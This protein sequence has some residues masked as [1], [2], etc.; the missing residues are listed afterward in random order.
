MRLLDFVFNGS[1]ALVITQSVPIAGVL[2]VFSF[3][4]VP[5][6]IGALLAQRLPTRLVIGVAGRHRPEP[7]RSRHR[8]ARFRCRQRDSARRTSRRS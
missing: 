4:L 7:M 1:F 8:A 5:A 6:T 3:L 2:L